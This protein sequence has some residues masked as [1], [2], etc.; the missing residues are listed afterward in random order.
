M[1]VDEKKVNQLNAVKIVNKKFFGE[2][3]FSVLQ[4]IPLEIKLFILFNQPFKLEFNYGLLIASNDY[5]EFNIKQIP[6]VLLS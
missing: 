4:A 3:T 6:I 2:V 5:I 1:R